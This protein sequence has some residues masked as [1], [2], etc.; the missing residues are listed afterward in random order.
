MK[1]LMFIAFLAFIYYC[2]FLITCWVVDR[3]DVYVR[4]YPGNMYEI[5]FISIMTTL[6]LTICFNFKVMEWLFNWFVVP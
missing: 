4:R 3:R 2:N 6:L 5:E 1:I